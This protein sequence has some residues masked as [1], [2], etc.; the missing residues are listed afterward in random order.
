MDNHAH[1][2]FHWSGGPLQLIMGA[3]CRTPKWCC[4]I[5]AHYIGVTTVNLIKNMPT[6]VAHHIDRCLLPC[7][8]AK[9]HGPP[10]PT[11]AGPGYKDVVSEPHS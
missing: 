11:R 4:G 7:W 8:C 5:M 10:K 1:T 2:I 6:L 3:G 9:G